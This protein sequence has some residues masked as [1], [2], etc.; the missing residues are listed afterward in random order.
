MADAR[1]AQMGIWGG[2][3]E[4]FSPCFNGVSSICWVS[5]A[6]EIKCDRLFLE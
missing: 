6:L 4:R 2:G 3:G 1:E 5:F